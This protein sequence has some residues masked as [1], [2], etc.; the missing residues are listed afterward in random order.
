MSN[1][2]RVAMT[3]HGRER[4]TRSRFAAGGAAFLEAQVR[5]KASSTAR[6]R[7]AGVGAMLAIAVAVWGSPFLEA[8]QRGR[9]GG[10]PPGPPPTGQSAAPIDVTGYWVSL[11]V[12]EWRFRVSPQKGDIAYLPINAAAR[13]IANNWDPAKDEAAGQQCRAYGAVGIM[14]RPGRLHIT[15]QDPNTLKI[16]ADAGT[17]TRLIHFTAAPADPGP[18]TWQG[19]STGNWLVNGRL[20]IDTGGTGVVP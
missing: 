7:A 2:R 5:G 8:Q 10:P 3:R 16:E 4:W 1:Q 11:I 13:E 20:L 15:W 17:Q 18:R 14:Q 19:Y 12:D 9:R 6:G